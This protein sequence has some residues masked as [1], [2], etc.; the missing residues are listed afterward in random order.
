[1]PHRRRWTLNA[2][3][4]ALL[5]VSGAVLWYGNQA[6]HLRAQGIRQWIQMHLHLG[7]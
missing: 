3:L 4:L 2:A 1:L 7:Q 6:G 5:A